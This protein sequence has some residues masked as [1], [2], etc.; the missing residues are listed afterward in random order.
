MEGFKTI[1]NRILKRIAKKILLMQPEI[2]E[3]I[4]NEVIKKEQPDEIWPIIK[5]DTNKGK[6]VTLDNGNIQDAIF[7][8]TEYDEDGFEDVHHDYILGLLEE[9][10]NLP[11]DSLFAREKID[12]NTKLGFVTTWK[13]NAFIFYCIN[14]NIYEVKD[15][16]L[17][18]T[19]NIKNV[20]DD[21]IHKDWKNNVQVFDSI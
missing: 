14:T 18:Y 5:S 4:K 17:E 19:P 11:K 10:H 8:P 12:K 21:T 3:N 13:D 2:N 16:I 7:V 1:M 20:Y 9:K 15:L 6:I